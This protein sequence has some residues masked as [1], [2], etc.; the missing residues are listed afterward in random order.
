MTDYTRKL[1]PDELASIM[2]LRN[3]YPMAAQLD[4]ILANFEKMRR[5]IKRAQIE[6]LVLNALWFGLGCLVTWYVMATVAA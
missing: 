6:N 5:E 4:E 2:P 1:S 3:E